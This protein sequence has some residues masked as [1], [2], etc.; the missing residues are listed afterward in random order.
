MAFAI[1]VDGQPVEIISGQPF[2][3]T[4]FKITTDDEAAWSF[5]PI[6]TVI[7][8]EVGHGGTA[9]DAWDDADRA[10]YC[11]HTFALPVAPDGKHLTGY[12][13][14]LDGDSIV[15]TGVFAGPI[16]P[17]EVSRLQA[18]QALRIAGELAAVET[19]IAAGSEEVQI[20]WADAS[21]FHRNHPTLLAMS[22]ALSM[23][24][25]DVDTLFIAA[26]QIT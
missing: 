23:S 13:L 8:K 4:Q 26:S 3:S 2:T 9:L 5:E 19:A 11:V 1:I 24:P 20:Y 10:R 17:P 6:G 18:K 22:A 21:M 12:T 15:A 25:D 16:V 7:D 14:T